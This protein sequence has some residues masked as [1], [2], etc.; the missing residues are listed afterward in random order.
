MAR[1]TQVAHKKTGIFALFFLEIRAPPACLCRPSRSLSEGTQRNTQAA[2]LRARALWPF[3]FPC[4][5]KYYNW[6]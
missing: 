4:F 2:P 6:P 5:P 3:A 1:T